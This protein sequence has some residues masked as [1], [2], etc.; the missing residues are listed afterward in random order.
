[1]KRL[2]GRLSPF[3]AGQI[4]D[5]IDVE[6]TIAEIMIFRS[7]KNWPDKFRVFARDEN[8]KIINEP[9]FHLQATTRYLMLETLASWKNDLPPRREFLDPPIR[10]GI[11]S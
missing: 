8:G 5:G 4:L 6:G 7:C 11:W 9:R 10:T 1:M 3:S 2:I